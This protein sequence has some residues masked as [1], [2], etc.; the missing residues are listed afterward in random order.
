MDQKA[1][2]VEPG[3]PVVL[4]QAELHCRGGLQ[5]PYGYHRFRKE[6]S[7]R[8]L[9]A[10]AL[11]LSFFLPL[12]SPAEAQSARLPRKSRAE[13]QVEEINRNLRQGDR[14]RQLDQQYQIDN[15]QLRQNF[16]RQRTL[17]SPPG[18]IGTC[19]VGSIGC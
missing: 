2:G 18:R 11:V 17:S 3:I 9:V 5:E 15:N 10:A 13:R 14:L 1:N 16:D 7:M 8:T 12:V 6:C 4:P 19:P